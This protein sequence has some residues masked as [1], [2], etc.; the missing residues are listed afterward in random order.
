MQQLGSDWEVKEVVRSL[1]T[2][3]SALQVIV[4]GLEARWQAIDAAIANAVS[5]VEEMAAEKDIYGHWRRALTN[6]LERIVDHPEVVS[7]AEEV[8]QI[9][10]GNDRQGIIFVQVIE[11]SEERLVQDPGSGGLLASL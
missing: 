1:V 8:K 10:L 4:A 6:A 5:G 9:E 2:D 7:V 11:Y 3:V